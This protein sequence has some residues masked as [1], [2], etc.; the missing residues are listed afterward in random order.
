MKTKNS[1][2]VDALRNAIVGSLAL[3]TGRKALIKTIAG[4]KVVD[5]EPEAALLSQN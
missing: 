5:Q 2:K 4:V 1:K 3:A